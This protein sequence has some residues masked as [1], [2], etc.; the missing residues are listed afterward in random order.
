MA[1][2]SSLSVV[3][4]S[5]NKKA[6]FL[7]STDT[8]EAQEEAELECQPYF[9]ELTQLPSDQVE[10]LRQTGLLPPQLSDDEQHDKTETGGS[11]DI[12]VVRQKHLDYLSQVWKSPPLRSAF[13]SLDASRPWMLYWCLHGCDLL[14][15]IPDD[16]TC[17]GMVTTL[18]A[19]WESTTVRLKSRENSNNIQVEGD[20]LLLKKTEDANSTAVE[21]EFVAGGFGG[22]PGRKCAI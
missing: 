5:N 13:V 4:N 8:T 11:L 17:R 15:E 20:V 12:C 6:A 1:S 22:G 7:K 9:V 19:C 10:H 18:Q 21:N 3:N 14:G 2:T 16:V